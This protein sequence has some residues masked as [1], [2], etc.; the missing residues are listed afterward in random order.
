MV[1]MQ[2]NF[3]KD[4]EI[5]N[6]EQEILGRFASIIAKQLLKGKKVAIINAEKALLSGHKKD[7]IKKYRTKLNLIE[8][9]N[10]T[11]S[12]YWSRRPDLLV[13][14]IVRGMLPYRKPIGKLAYK[15][16]YVFIDQPE[17]IKPENIKKLNIK[18]PKKIFVN[19]ISI[20]ELSKLLGYTVKV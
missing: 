20:K 16:L 4:F 8:K 19:T 14:R 17:N 15:R 11:H 10:P 5:Y 6:A 7:I 2:I 1:I 13:K 12:P 3:D 9:A 18:D